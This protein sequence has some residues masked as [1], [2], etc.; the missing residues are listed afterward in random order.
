VAQQYSS[1][2]PQVA[3]DVVQE[4][5]KALRGELRRMFD[6]GVSHTGINKSL[7]PF[8]YQA[9]G[10]STQAWQLFD[11]LLGFAA[12]HYIVYVC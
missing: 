9:R 6:T 2:T 10:L 3:T 11:Q 8:A 12:G 1:T 5:A 7:I 4:T